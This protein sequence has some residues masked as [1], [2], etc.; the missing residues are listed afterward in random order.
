MC[1]N[2]YISTEAVSCDDLRPRALELD[3]PGFETNLHLL[4][5]MALR[6]SHN[7]SVLVSMENGDNYK[8]YPIGLLEL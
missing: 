4:R 3:I 8:I 7:F 1:I 5:G 6:K 2:K